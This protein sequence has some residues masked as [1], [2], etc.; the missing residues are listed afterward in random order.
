MRNFFFL[1][2]K[3]SKTVWK[4]NISP[5]IKSVRLLFS[6]WLMFSYIS[7]GCKWAQKES[8]SR[9]DKSEEVN[10]WELCKRLIFDRIEKWYVHK[11]G[12]HGIMVTLIENRYNDLIQI[13]DKS[14]CISESANTLGKGMNPIIIPP[15]MS[16]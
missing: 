9:Y 6:S 16:K 12:C 8:R 2:T 13:S 14:V 1:S 5:S 7:E 3:P 4:K 10:H 15:V 11:G